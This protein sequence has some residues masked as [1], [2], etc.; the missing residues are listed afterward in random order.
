M[1][2]KVRI[3]IPDDVKFI[4]R[5]LKDNGHEA[6]AVGGCVRDV[7]LGKDPADWDLTTDADPYVVKDIFHRTIDTGLKHGTVT[8]MIHGTGYEVTT[9]RIDGDYTDSR[10]PENVEFTR[11]LSE[12]LKRRDFTINAMAF[13]DDSGVVDHFNGLKDLDDHIIRCVGDPVERFTEDALRIMR[14]VRFSC[15]LGFDIEPATMDAAKEKASELTHISAERIR[16]ELLKSVTAHHPEK[17]FGYE[18]AGIFKIVLPELSRAFECPQE[19][20]HHIF[21]AGTHMIMSV[22]NM[23]FLLDEREPQEVRE[24]VKDFYPKEHLEGYLKAYEKARVLFGR[25]LEN[26]CNAAQHAVKDRR[27]ISYN[28][29]IHDDD[30]NGSGADKTEEA[31]AISEKG[32]ENLCMTMLLHDIAKPVVKT[33]DEEGH[34][35]FIGHAAVG[36]DMA[37]KI[38]K[39]LKFDNAAVKDVTHMVEYHDYRTY[40]RKKNVRKMIA[41]IGAE[42]IRQVFLVQLSDILAQAPELFDDKFTYT[43]EE[44]EMAEECIALD[45][46]FTIKDLDIDGRILMDELG[47][48]GPEIG[49]ILNKLLEL[50]LDDPENNRKEI[51]LRKA[52]D[53]NDKK[54]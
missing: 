51:L 40:P 21:D 16:T 37:E 26:I 9:Y 10:H 46:P 35:H 45:C 3:N 47:L 31:H 39:R 22:I 48:K 7:F 43:L 23:D 50:V 20:E 38:M 54:L 30:L 52:S 11:D 14:A 18:Q 24:L 29:K 5:R 34:A 36:K 6:Y 19:T 2:K 15:Q 27:S 1:D 28:E 8:V 32:R 53:I 4:I 49:N 42:Y 41:K 12:D 17:L 44:Y 13:N 25:V 33:Y